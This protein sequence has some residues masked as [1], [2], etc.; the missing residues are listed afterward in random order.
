MSV[1]VQ[2]ISQ[3]PTFNTPSPDYNPQ[4]VIDVDDNSYVVYTTTG[5][6]S[7][8]TNVGGYDIVIFK[9]NPSGECLW[10]TQQPVFNTDQDDIDPVIAIDAT[11]NLF[12]SYSTNGGA[13]SG[14]TLTGTTDIVVFKIEPVNGLC[15]WIAQQPTFNT[16]ISNQSP[17]ITVDA[18]GY[19]CVAYST[20]GTASGQIAT[21]DQDIVAFKLDPDT[22]LCL[23]VTQQPS[24]NAIGANTYPNVKTDSS[25]NIYVSYQT[26]GTSSGQTLTGSSYDI[27]VF[28]LNPSGSCLWVVQQPI[29][30]ASNNNIEPVVTIDR[31]GYIYVAYTTQG[32]ASGQTQTGTTDI[33][34]FKL[35]P[36]TGSCIWIT[37]QP[38]FNTA[39][40]NSAPTIS[41]DDS[42]SVYVAYQTY[43]VASGQTHLGWARDI[44][45]FKLEPRHGQCVWVTQQAS[46]NTINDDI[47][48][49]MTVDP[50]GNIY[51]TYQTAGTTSGQTSTGWTDIV[52]FKVSPPRPEIT[53]GTY[54][55][56]YTGSAS[57]GTIVTYTIGFQ[58]TG[59]LPLTGVVVTDNLGNSIP[60]GSLAVGQSQTVYGTYAM[61][62]RDIDLGVILSQATATGVYLTTMV[63]GYNETSVVPVILMSLQVS[64]YTFDPYY[65]LTVSNTGN[66]SLYS[67]SV[68]DPVTGINTVIPELSSNESHT[69]MGTQRGNKN[70]AIDN[71]IDI[72]E[73]NKTIASG[74]TRDQIMVTNSG[75][76]SALLCVAHGTMILMK[77]GTE[78]PIQEIKRGDLV[79]PNHQVSRLCQTVLNPAMPIKVVTF[80]PKSLSPNQPSRQLTMTEGHPLI[81]DGARRPARCFSGGGIKRQTTTGIS[82]LYDLQFDYDASYLANSVEIQSFSPC[83]ID[84]HL[85]KQLYHNPDMY[86][87]ECIVDR[88]DHPLELNTSSVVTSG[89]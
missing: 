54:F 46:F 41:I 57:V 74:S 58:N 17:S 52:V 67:V 33:V 4:I 88:Y 75:V 7:G 22:G 84:Y 2:W 50:I 3:Q 10:L 62:Q 25:D 49:N 83:H 9:L 20:N 19:V 63:A 87:D 8:Q 14:Q 76:V 40:I 35:D 64:R 59:N 31:T 38:S 34:V 73:D 65:S 82:Y 12:V 47:T 18:S 48:P 69:I 86:T 61:T 43:G 30:N 15:L 56:T 27:V 44:V 1:S 11:G 51:V 16:D 81:Y 26:T 29:F 23:W 80:E 70:K 13:S 24:F 72:G 21:G 32:V 85:P 71:G 6:A 53:L 39:N 36:L 79:A 37:Q 45:I 77:D 60:V 66:V 55:G 28:K 68:T 89:V 42:R 78:K 5:T